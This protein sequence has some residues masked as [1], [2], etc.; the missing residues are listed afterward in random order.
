MP[1]TRRTAH[2]ASQLPVLEDDAL[3]LVIS[4]LRSTSDLYNAAMVCKAW[5]TTARLE[6]AWE[7][8]AKGTFPV[9]AHAAVYRSFGILGVHGWKARCKLLRQREVPTIV[10]NVHGKARELSEKY[11][12]VVAVQDGDGNSV[13][14]PAALG[15]DFLDD[16]FALHVKFDEPAALNAGVCGEWLQED[17]DPTRYGVTDGFGVANVDVFVRRVTDGKVALFATFK[18]NFDKPDNDIFGSH[19]ARDDDNDAAQNDDTV[20]FGH[21]AEFARVSSVPWLWEHVH[22]VYPN[23]AWGRS[24]GIRNF[25]RAGRLRPRGVL[26]WPHARGVEDSFEPDMKMQLGVTAK[27]PPLYE[28]ITKTGKWM[29]LTVRFRW[30]FD[31]ASEHGGNDVEV[32]NHFMA[33]ALDGRAIAWV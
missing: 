15:R 21:E 4:Q 10:E 32:E 23:L 26:Q 17:S 11:T 31:F 13:S 8:A 2:D 12:Y 22:D 3:L 19:D 25:P 5:A 33:Q 29:E 28:P 6:A 14:S 18:F 1:R 9:E 27:A 24:D 20:T 7:N 30:V 16:A